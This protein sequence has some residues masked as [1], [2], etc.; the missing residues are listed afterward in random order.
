M[1]IKKIMEMIS[2]GV[3]A[4]HVQGRDFLRIDEEIEKA[5]IEL[6]FKVLEWNLGYGW[7]DFK[8]KR[9]LNIEKNSSL[10]EDLKVLADEDPKHKIYV[11]K[12]AFSALSND[13]KACA[14]L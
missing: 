8:S 2:S 5:S 9:A 4:I 1:N 11:I 7:V 3:A 13:Y 6:G 14:C 12:N 10:Y